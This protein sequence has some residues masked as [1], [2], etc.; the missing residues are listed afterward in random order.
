MS[1]QENAVSEKEAEAKNTSQAPAQETEIKEE[2][3]QAGPEVLETEKIET[4]QEINEESAQISQEEYE[5]L[6]QQV[7]S[8][9]DSWARER[10]EFQN[11]KRRTAV[12]FSNIRKESVKNFVTNLLNPLDNL[13]RVA[14]DTSSTDI[15]PF[16]EGVEMIRKEFL[17][18]L[19]K[20]NIQRFSPQ[21]EAFDPMR[22]EAIASEELEDIDEEKVTEV[23]QSGYQLV[24]AENSDQQP[25]IIR[26]SRVKVGRP[27]NT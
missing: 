16:Q 5:K 7:Q 23:Y 27:K 18:V 8:L 1:E 3:F 26:P 21:G 10:A 19:E 25:I 2:T 6:Q 4:A 14:S 12:E 11:Y 15:K 22:M 20:E 24:A 17:T 9:K 13:E